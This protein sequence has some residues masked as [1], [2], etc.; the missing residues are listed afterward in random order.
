MVLSPIVTGIN[1][2][3]CGRQILSPCRTNHRQGGCG[4]QNEEKFP[5]GSLRGFALIP[6]SSVSYQ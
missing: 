5:H 1:P 4:R 3:N 6:G 2:A